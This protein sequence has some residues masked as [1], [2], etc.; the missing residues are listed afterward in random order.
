MNL[1]KSAQKRK[2]MFQNFGTKLHNDAES[3]L[4]KNQSGDVKKPRRTSVKAFSSIWKRSRH[5]AIIFAE[6]ARAQ[7]QL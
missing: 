4:K 3:V 7:Q 1:F 6:R 5:G 2:K